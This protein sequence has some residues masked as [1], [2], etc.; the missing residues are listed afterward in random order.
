MFSNFLLSFL[1]KTP[2]FNVVYDS[3][4]WVLEENWLYSIVTSDQ[5]RCSHLSKTHFSLS[6]Y[7]HYNQKALLQ[8]AY[9]LRPMVV[10]TLSRNAAHPRVQ[11][12]KMPV[13]IELLLEAA[14]VTCTL[15]VTKAI[16]SSGSDPD[17]QGT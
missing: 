9:I 5:S 12:I 1:D 17:G 16:S 4:F 3:L 6:V 13:S 14:Q 11:R 8:L 2:P 7:E 10:A 15:S